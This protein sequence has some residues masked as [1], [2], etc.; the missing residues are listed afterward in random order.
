MLHWASS[1]RIPSWG[2][3]KMCSGERTCAEL[4]A[5]LSARVLERWVL[6]LDALAPRIVGRNDALLAS[7]RVTRVRVLFVALVR[8]LLP[9]RDGRGINHVHGPV[10]ARVHEV[11]TVDALAPGWADFHADLGRCAIRAGDVAPLAFLQLEAERP[12]RAQ[13]GADQ[14]D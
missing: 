13:Q 4:R 11:V 8:T 7:R 1:R 10:A 9:T 14:G 6:T 12:P 3:R 2:A 5:P